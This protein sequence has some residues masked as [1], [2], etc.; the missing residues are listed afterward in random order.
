MSENKK[1]Y[2]LKLQKT[3]FSDKKIKKM[4]RK[5]K[6]RKRRRMKEAEEKR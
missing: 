1:Y 3:F 4:R 2:W 5:Q 6:R